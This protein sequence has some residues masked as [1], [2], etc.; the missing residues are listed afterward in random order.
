[1]EACCLVHLFSVRLTFGVDSSVHVLWTFNL[2]LNRSHLSVTGIT[3]RAVHTRHST[4]CDKRR[5]G[6]LSGCDFA[7]R[8]SVR[9][10]FC[11]F[12]RLWSCF[13][14]HPSS[15]ALSHLLLLHILSILSPVLCSSC[16]PSCLLPPPTFT[17]P[18]CRQTVTVK[19]NPFLMKS[20]CMKMC[21]A[22]TLRKMKV[23]VCM[24]ESKR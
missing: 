20:N 22:G 2:F 11:C 9:F 14:P 24:C 3:D 15:A 16:L 18:P 7:L 21:C 13:L 17:R 10:F 19:S 1:M 5:V 8:A 6:C 4:I 12:P 23:Y